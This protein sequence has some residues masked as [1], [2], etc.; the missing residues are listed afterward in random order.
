MTSLASQV[1]D[2]LDEDLKKKLTWND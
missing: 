2:G 1:K